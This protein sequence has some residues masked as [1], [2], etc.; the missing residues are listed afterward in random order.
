MT[1]EYIPEYVIQAVGKITKVD[2]K[3]R[4]DS[5]DTTDRVTAFQEPEHKT[6][7]ELR[8]RNDKKT[9]CY[10]PIKYTKVFNRTWSLLNMRK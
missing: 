4:V 9:I 5:N 7:V 10:Y 1:A 3:V 6:R 2:Y 8:S